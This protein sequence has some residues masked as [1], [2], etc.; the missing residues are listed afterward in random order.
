MPVEGL[1]YDSV[2]GMNVTYKKI[3]ESLVI[4]KNLRIT[5]DRLA[6]IKKKFIYRM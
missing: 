6:R 1:V 3:R 4:I 5:K 2:T